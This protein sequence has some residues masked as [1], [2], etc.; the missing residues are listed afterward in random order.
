MYG[1]HKNIMKQLGDNEQHYVIEG[2][3]TLKLNKTI[4]YK[5]C[6]NFGE[7]FNKISFSFFPSYV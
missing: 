7:N 3:D 4:I 2:C 6:A 5:I 1:K